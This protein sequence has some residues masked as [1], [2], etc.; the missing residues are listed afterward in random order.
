VNVRYE[1]SDE[2]LALLMAHDLDSFNRWEASQQLATRVLLE[3]VETIRAAKTFT[4]PPLFSDAI[5]RVLTTARATRP[6]PPNACSCRARASSP[7][8]A[9]VPP[10]PMPSTRRA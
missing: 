3:G 4:V 6:S 8:A 1:Y 10:T 9:R 2:E 5:G 7:N